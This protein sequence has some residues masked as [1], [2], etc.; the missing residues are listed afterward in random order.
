MLTA[1]LV[2]D[3]ATI[4]D[5]LVP[6]LAELGGVEVLAMAEG[7]REALDWLSAHGEEADLV[8]LDLFLKDGSGL[9]VLARREELGLHRVVVLTNYATADIRRRC[10]K[11]GADA[12][13]DKSTEFDELLAYL[14]H[15]AAS[16][17]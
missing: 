9:G 10:L 17:S 11:L 4:R 15:A 13:F 5:V 1:Y 12:L 3:S 14:R 6:T 8:I 16:E 2:E 7:E